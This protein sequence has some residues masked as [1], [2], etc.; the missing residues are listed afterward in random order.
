[1]HFV[2]GL[3]VAFVLVILLSNRKTRNCRWRM[4]RARNQGDQTFFV[5][6]ACG[7]EVLTE[8]GQPPK[9]CSLRT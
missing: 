2:I 5:C 6:M 4:D 1:M 7:A 3:L 8:D 9:I